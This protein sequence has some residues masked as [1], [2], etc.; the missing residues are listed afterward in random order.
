MY[1]TMQFAA[2]SPPAPISVNAS[3]SVALISLDPFVKNA[4]INVWKIIFGSNSGKAITA[5]ENDSLIS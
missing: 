3:K 2:A 4:L 5:L 1:G